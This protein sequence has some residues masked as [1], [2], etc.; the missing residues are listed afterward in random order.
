MVTRKCCPILFPAMTS[1]MHSETP[2][3]LINCSS[4]LHSGVNAL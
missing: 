2:V 4:W 1:S 3:S